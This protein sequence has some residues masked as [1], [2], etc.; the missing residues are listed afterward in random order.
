MRLSGKVCVVSGGA[1][2]IG[3]AVADR[4]AAEGAIVYAGDMTIG[5]PS[6]NSAGLLMRPLSVQ[7]LASWERLATEVQA[8][9]GGADVLVNNAGMVHTYDTL[10]NV[11]L[12]A[13]DAVISVNQTGVF[14]GMRT[15][16]PQMI[17]RGGGSVVNISSIWGLVG[18]A[19]VAPYQAS[20]GAVTLMTKN[21]AL[22]YVESGIRVNSVHPGIISTPMIAAQ[23]AGITAAVVEA[24]PMKRAGRPEEI[25]NAVLFLASDEASY[26][27]GTQLCVDGGYTTQ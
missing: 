6:V 18:A 4:F 7:D 1:A 26:I 16:I 19:G 21:A 11:D 5:T 22:S 23:D 14:Y 17:E 13:W 2:G 3:R 20:K 24:T 15:F 25:A 8:E 27:T 10:T 12:A 9:H